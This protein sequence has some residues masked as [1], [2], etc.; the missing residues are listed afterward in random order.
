VTGVTVTWPRSGAA[1]PHRG[2][3]RAP[4]SRWP[5]PPPR[6]ALADRPR[7]LGHLRADPAVLGGRQYR[8]VRQ[9]R[10]VV[11][12]RF[13]QSPSPL[14]SAAQPGSAR[15]GLARAPWPAASGDRR[16]R[17]PPLGAWVWPQLLRRRQAPASIR[18]HLEQP[19]RPPPRRD[20]AARGAP[21]M[22]IHPARDATSPSEADTGSTRPPSAEPANA[23]RSANAATAA[24]H[25][26]HNPRQRP[27]RRQRL[28]FL[29]TRQPVSLTLRRT[30]ER[31][32]ARARIGAP[33]SVFRDD[34]EDQA[35]G[36]EDPD[37]TAW[38]RREGKSR[39][40]GRGGAKAQ[41]EERPP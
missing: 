9:S 7:H 11:P 4:R 16:F 33:R 18:A 14:V 1:R 6:C 10:L 2:A 27:S 28:G 40:P 36:A 22:P 34:N 23:A 30:P 5:W 15:A 21:T 12:C 19:A 20:P 24:Y 39:T 17:P 37:V 29:P 26:R 13:R 35:H 41:A 32:S 8:G 25:Q 38:A 3:T 31:L